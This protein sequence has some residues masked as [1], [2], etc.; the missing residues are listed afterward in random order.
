[1]SP[2][3]LAQLILLGLLTVLANVAY[4]HDQRTNR[5]LMLRF[6]RAMQT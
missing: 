5:A 2:V 4:Y 1:M 3:A 6:G